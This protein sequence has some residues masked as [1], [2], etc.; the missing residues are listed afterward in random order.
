MNLQSVVDTSIAVAATRSRLAKRAAIAQCFRIATVEDLPLMTHYL[1][2]TLPQGKIG[3][4]VSLLKAIGDTPPGA[5]A[6]LQLADIDDCFDE[7]AGISGKGAKTR[8]EQSLAQLFG[9]ATADEQAFLFRL[10]S[11]ELRQGALEGLMIDAMADAFELPAADLR[12][13]VMLSADPASVAV[14]ARQQGAAGLDSFRLVPLSPVKPMLAQPVD[15]IGG[16]LD[17][18]DR[19]S[20][21]VKLD[22][23][24]VQIHR[25]GDKVRIFTRALHEVSARLPEIVAQM[26]ALPDRSFIIDGEVIALRPDGR[27]QPFQVTMSRFG[28][29]AA[30]DLEKT[31][32]LSLFAFDCLYLNGV[33]LIDCSYRDRQ[34]ALNRLLDA[35]RIVNRLETESHSDAEAFLSAALDAGH[36]GIMAKSLDSVYAAGSRGGDWL[37]I[38]PTNTFDLVVLAAEWGSGRR[39]GWLSNLHLGARDSDG[40]FVMLGKTFKGL[41]DAMLEWQTA[42]LKSLATYEESHVVHVRPELVVEIAVNEIQKSRQYPGGMALRFARVKGYREDKSAAEADT[43]ES[44]RALFHRQFG[45]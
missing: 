30:G 11:G 15:D 36:E 18:F 14:A 7:I 32:P 39:K 2:G 31:L 5:Q 9:R 12:R 38:K 20:F 29:R 6:T 26:T 43:V 24:R 4:G 23:A 27:P 17:A 25:D 33:E 13:A 3:V 10:L 35:E 1:S 28:R 8:R 19:C 37:K 42:K 44:V 22:G 40:G 21:E 41:T 45:D 16:A 34:A